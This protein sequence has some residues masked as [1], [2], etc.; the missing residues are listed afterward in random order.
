MTA[1]DE[2]RATSG[3]YVQSLERGLAVIGVLD[4]PEPLTLSEVAR[5]AGLSRAA[6][7]R[8]VL[9]LEEL[10]YVRQSGGRFALTP[11]VLELGSAYL[12]SL[13]LPEIALPHVKALS[14]RVRESAV[15]SVLDGDSSVGIVRVPARRIITGTIVLG[16]RLPVWASASGRVLLSGLPPHERAEHVGRLAI[17][18]LTPK[19]VATHADLERELEV[20]RAQG[21]SLVD[22]ELE[23]GLRAL[24]APIRDRHGATVAALALVLQ[25]SG[26]DEVENVLVPPLRETCAA[27]E[28][29]LAAG[30]ARLGWTASASDVV[31]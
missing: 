23:I 30:D 10:G 13:T 26:P 8:F 14:E 9:T 4:A 25:A 29:D 21:W 27:I 5:R 3:Y 15:L 18:P 19:T 2:A 20:V 6:A 17:E 7:R 31:S 12:S 11:R 24:A 16:Q 28:R 22:Q 1:A